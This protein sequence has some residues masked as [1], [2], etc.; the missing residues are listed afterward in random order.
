MPARYV[1][2]NNYVIDFATG[3]TPFS[4]KQSYRS[5]AILKFR[6]KFLL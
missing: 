6:H 4:P 2:T 5:K 1:A 3:E